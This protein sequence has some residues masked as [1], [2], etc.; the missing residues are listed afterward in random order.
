MSGWYEHLPNQIILSIEGNSIILFDT[1]KEIVYLLNWIAIL[2]AMIGSIFNYKAWISSKVTCFS[3]VL[4][5][6]TLLRFYHLDAE[7]L[8]IDEIYSIRDA[9]SIEWMFENHNYNRI[10]YFI[11]L[12]AWMLLG[13]SEVWLRSLSNIFGIISIVLTYNLGSQLFSKQV[14]LTASLLLALSPLAINHSQEV[15]MYMLSTC[16]GLIGTLYLASFLK[17]Q[18]SLPLMGWFAARV[19]AILV[20]PVNILLYLPDSVLLLC[21][22]KLKGLLKVVRERKKTSIFILLVIIFPLFLIFQ[23]SFSPIINFIQNSRSTGDVDLSLFSFVGGIV[24]FMV[25]P[26]PDHSEPSAIAA[27]VDVS[28]KVYGILTIGVIATSAW[29]GKAFKLRQS[30]WILAWGFLPLISFFVVCVVLTPSLWGVSRYVVM[31][32]PYIFVALAVGFSRVWESKKRVAVLVGAAYMIATLFSLT[33]YYGNDLREDWRQVVHYI[34]EHEQSGD[35]ILVSAGRVSPVFTYYYAGEAPIISLDRISGEISEQLRN[36]AFEERLVNADSHAWRILAD[37]FDDRQFEYSSAAHHSLW[38]IV[39]HLH[40]SPEE[41]QVLEF[42]ELMQ[43]HFKRVE[44]QTFTGIEVFIL[45]NDEQLS[46]WQ[47]KDFSL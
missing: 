14:G 3:I 37:K 21:N 7:S 6:G 12:R 15:R 45:T 27:V 30:L 41:Q 10:L 29:Q 26:W 25:W 39:P 22:L 43:R 19:L 20:T 28:L 2:S 17:T 16:L 23:S 46:S 24:R 33:N 38:F 9:A 1:Q 42:E 36:N 11:L 44:R 32:A 5:V 35:A 8:W 13:T 47:A 18:K 34:S 4:F 40:I 31:L